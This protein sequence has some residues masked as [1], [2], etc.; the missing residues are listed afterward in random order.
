[1]AD[2]LETKPKTPYELFLERK[3]AVEAQVEE[4]P[5]TQPAQPAPEKPPVAQTPYD[6]FMQRKAEV[7][8][9]ATQPSQPVEP[10]IEQPVEPKTTG[11]QPEA[12][13]M[14]TLP[15]AG[16]TMGDV[17]P[18]P[19]EHQ[20][21]YTSEDGLIEA[22]TIDVEKRIVVDNKDGSKSTE[23]SFSVGF[24]G[25][26][27]LI[28]QVVNGKMLS[29]KEAIEHYKKT[30][31]HLGKFDTT[32]SADKF[33]VKLHE[34]QA[35]RYKD[36]VQSGISKEPIQ[37]TERDGTVT[38]R[39]PHVMATPEGGFVVMPSMANGKDADEGVAAG[40]YL[41]DENKSHYGKFKTREA[42]EAEADR[43]V[44]EESAIL[45]AEVE[46]Y[47]KMVKP[48]DFGY[49]PKEQLKPTGSQP[50][51]DLGIQT[52]SPFGNQ[53]TRDTVETQHKKM[54]AN[55][56]K[57][58]KQV[59]DYKAFF[60]EKSM[61]SM[62]ERAWQDFAT[63]KDPMKGFTDW[64][65]HSDPDK[66]LDRKDIN[67]YIRAYTI[68]YT[69][70]VL[71][72]QYSPDRPI[73]MSKKYRDL[74]R[75][76]Q[77]G[78]ADS[79]LNEIDAE[80]AAQKESINENMRAILRADI[81]RNMPDNNFLRNMITGIHGGM[82]DIASIVY[83]MK[84]DKVADTILDVANFS[85][86]INADIDKVNNV[87]EWWANGVRGSFR[88]TVPL[89]PGILLSVVTG[90]GSLGAAISISSAT[91][92]RGNQAIKEGKDAGLTGDDLYSYVTRAAAIEMLVATAF[93]AVGHGGVEKM[94]TQGLK[95]TGKHGLANALKNLGISI[96][97]ELMEEIPT[98]LL[99]MVNQK[100]SKVDLTGYNAEQTGEVIFATLVQ[101]LMVSA[102]LGS[103][104]VISTPIRTRSRNR[105]IDSISKAH[106]ITE[107]ALREAWDEGEVSL[108]GVAYDDPRRNQIFENAVDNHLV[109]NGHNA[110][111]SN[112]APMIKN[113]PSM[114]RSFEAEEI[115][116]AK[117]RAGVVKKADEGIARA[118]ETAERIRKEREGREALEL[119]EDKDMT[120][121]VA[122]AER[123]RGPADDQVILEEE[124]EEVTPTSETQVLQP[125][126]QEISESETLITEQAE[127]TV[128]EP[129]A[130]VEP[131]KP[132]V[133]KK[134][135]N[136]RAENMA[137]EQPLSA[138]VELRDMTEKALKNPELSATERQRWEKQMEVFDAAI[139]IKVDA[140]ESVENAR[141]I[142]LQ[143]NL[144]G[145]KE[146]S[147]FEGKTQEE[148]DA[149][150]AEQ[151]AAE[152][153]R[154]A[155]PLYPMNKAQ[156]IDLA[157]SYGVK[158]DGMTK[159]ELI[160]EIKDWRKFNQEAR[161]SKKGKTL[162]EVTEPKPIKFGR[163][164]EAE[165]EKKARAKQKVDVG[166]HGSL[167]LG[168]TK[169][170][171]DVVIVRKDGDKVFVKE[172]G[173]GQEIEID[174]ANF[175]PES[176]QETHDRVQAEKKEAAKT[177]QEPDLKIAEPIAETEDEKHAREAS[178]REA[179]IREAKKAQK[180]L[181]KRQSQRQGHIKGQKG[182]Y[183][184]G[185]NPVN[186]KLTGEVDPNGNP[187]MIDTDTKRR[188]TLYNE[189][190]FTESIEVGERKSEAQRDAEAQADIQKA[191]DE[192]MANLSAEDVAEGDA[193]EAETETEAKKD[194]AEKVQ[195]DL[196]QEQQTKQKLDDFEAELR[197]EED[198]KKKKKPPDVDP[199]RGGYVMNPF[200]AIAEGSKEFKAALVIGK[201]LISKG[202]N[203]FKSW[204]V[205]MVKNLGGA[206]KNNL[207]A[208][209]IQAKRKV[210]G[211]VRGLTRPVTDAQLEE[212]RRIWREIP[213]V[214]PWKPNAIF[215]GIPGMPDSHWKALVTIGKRIIG[216]GFTSSK[217]FKTALNKWL[218]ITT[219]G[220]DIAPF[221]V[222]EHK[223]I[224]WAE[225]L[226]GLNTDGMEFSDDD[227]QKRG[228]F[229]DEV[230]DNKI[231]RNNAKGLAIVMLAE[232]QQK[233]ALDE[234]MARINK[235]KRE[236]QAV[237][238][239]R[240][241][242]EAYEEAIEADE[243]EIVRT[244]KQLLDAAMALYEEITGENWRTG[245]PI[246]QNAERIS[247]ITDN[248]RKIIGTRNPVAS[249]LLDKFTEMRK[250]SEA[251]RKVKPFDTAQLNVL[252]SILVEVRASINADNNIVV[253]NND[254]I[255]NEA[256]ARIAQENTIVA[257]SL[258]MSR[259]DEATMTDEQ[260]N[261]EQE[262]IDESLEVLSAKAANKPRRITKPLRE[263]SESIYTGLE[264]QAKKKKSIYNPNKSEEWNR[265]KR[266]KFMGKAFAGQGALYTPENVALQ[267]G[268]QDVSIAQQMGLVAGDKPLAHTVFSENIVNGNRTAKK[269][270]L[271]SKAVIQGL[272][273]KTDL[274]PSEGNTTRNM[275]EFTVG[276]ETVDLNVGDVM[277]LYALSKSN[278]SQQFLKKGKKNFASTVTPVNMTPEIAEAMFAK[279]TP[280]ERAVV[281]AAFEYMNDT[282]DSGLTGR[283]V[284]GW[285]KEHG[286]PWD[287]AGGFWPSK[288]SGRSTD[289]SG[290]ISKVFFEQNAVGGPT[291][292]GNTSEVGNFFKM[293][294]NHSEHVAQNTGLGLPIR[295]ARALLNDTT[296]KKGLKN[297]NA[298]DVGKYFAEYIDDID[299]R[300]K[301]KEPGK[302]KANQIVGWLYLSA[303]AG[304]VG[305]GLKQMASL[306]YALN[307]MSNKYLHAGRG[308]GEVL[309]KA[310]LLSA[311]API[312]TPAALAKMATNEQTR[313]EMTEHSPD[314]VERQVGP[315]SGII[316]PKM[317]REGDV[318]RTMSQFYL[319]SP[320]GRQD[321][322]SSGN[323]LS[324]LQKR[325]LN[326]TDRMTNHIK[327][328]DFVTI[329]KIWEGAKREGQEKYGLE[330]DT[331]MEYTAR[332]TEQIVQ[333][334]QPTFDD[335]HKSR[336]GRRAKEH[337]WAKFMSLFSSQRNKN[338]NQLSM[339]RWKAR[340]SID[341]AQARRT[342]AKS[343]AT[344][345]FSG[346]VMMGVADYLRDVYEDWF[347]D[348]MGWA[349]GIEPQ[350]KEIDPELRA[351]QAGVNS[352]TGLVYGGQYVGDV[353][354]E[355][356]A[357]KITG[358]GMPNFEET[359]FG[360]AEQ[361]AKGTLRVWD[362][363]LT[364]WGDEDWTEKQQA[365]FKK[366]M[367]RN[368][369]FFGFPSFWE[370]QTRRY[371]DLGQQK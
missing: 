292:I 190:K 271:E 329:S 319:D 62:R 238:D 368:A 122:A 337:M 214:A 119:I 232:A 326:Q 61:K 19:P 265:N 273:E 262:T 159:K 246:R 88:S 236:Q 257:G 353:V 304:N 346:A 75:D 189:D 339:A 188:M 97:E 82:S 371:I 70:N 286:I 235:E 136:K 206:V 117:E 77:Q 49:Q 94:L 151:E 80:R 302:D 311:A 225:S 92:I 118:E 39:R 130:V 300:F 30:N 37:R 60:G 20:V 175:F 58:E 109:Q 147:R 32:E 347:W 183:M 1:M 199:R 352:I 84:G 260:R 71:K 291:E 160:A 338:F 361:L 215:T 340:N 17:Q 287:I 56:A 106:D 87:A 275:R 298:E 114:R 284:E 186:V 193:L 264:E 83:R 72:A 258:A 285:N 299:R 155:K 312:G 207:R 150:A 310:A 218:N 355:A 29:K 366:Q 220:Q 204:S 194:V 237:D 234:E 178:D 131:E 184:E 322:K 139:Q 216:K 10:P 358:K 86:E 321:K 318:D 211:V 293:Y 187:L 200:T 35:E 128:I 313:S 239:G 268:S 290:Y 263:V 90:G 191:V 133:I 288:I 315:V 126:E 208:L 172:E 345:L 123:G 59:A 174:K 127:G 145:Y 341:K 209:W 294:I 348:A 33:A 222:E 149:K 242:D 144:D 192:A 116:K 202:Y 197:A 247:E 267:M 73:E 121:E 13:Q 57:H 231:E 369:K 334:T 274:D 162:E 170:E 357:R 195:K 27:V 370:R 95:G 135:A 367:L 98:E 343:Y 181:A 281:D 129:A 43:R 328:I 272:T 245:K 363:M 180:E 12:P 165:Q 219:E 179:P 36:V 113:L 142:A 173:F 108:E 22:G 16:I 15:E 320:R 154:D 40:I 45:D 228:D 25:K 38:V 152:I 176:F 255:T 280:E 99:D 163:A 26:Q 153:A 359:P 185:N 4:V 171:I 226:A 100:F 351:V 261:K 296:F 132:K 21:E 309:G 270:K 283:M 349:R 213:V 344:V 5:Q 182:V 279:L 104:S 111:F 252:N 333:R 134:I 308:T 110:A 115:R 34:E 277:Q 102:A 50:I 69:K 156:L 42:A 107:K 323:V 68:E 297:A 23:K 3:A 244:D 157:A 223:E 354:M 64:L 233:L 167:D 89:V 6:L 306:N 360:Q 196:T 79:I 51:T 317:S 365:E 332:R 336:Y 48:R 342:V 217:D 325:A 224:A 177:P 8:A 251:G 14:G 66:K 103:P 91:A 168:G 230:V 259:L 166:Q 138:I 305:V 9:P 67:L 330:G 227:N 169:G 303:L 31:E 141:Q 146:I 229:I 362:D 278:K 327:E 124:M 55:V 105:L 76:G 161:D 356:A 198:A 120:E 240:Q 221:M 289:S 101:T 295:Q 212:A 46:E 44:K 254:N 269:I 11:P 248:L 249:N 364:S 243:E 256:Q 74:V 24:D 205:Q 54:M 250:I 276:E 148:K 307:E 18:T 28:P 301:P 158:T 324:K 335:I 140:G 210:G 350:K 93:L 143:S 201:D 282:A 47:K 85:D 63:N 2:T 314:L 112:P 253:D 7:E 137:K 266:R 164:L 331:L 96:G 65:K 316:G 241:I 125:A 81:E 52:I 78:F 53:I 41:D 203:N